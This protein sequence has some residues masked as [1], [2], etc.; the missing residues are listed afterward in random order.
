MNDR[1]RNAS[2]I[3]TESFDL[4]EET[5][6]AMKSW[7]LI[8][9][10]DVEDCFH[11]YY[12]QYIQ[13][14]QSDFAHK[15]MFLLPAL[16]DDGCYTKNGV[17][18]FF[19]ISSEYKREMMNCGYASVQEYN[20]RFTAICGRETTSL[21]LIDPSKHQSGFAFSIVSTYNKN[22]GSEV[23]RNEKVIIYHKAKNDILIDSDIEGVV[24][25]RGFPWYHDN[26]EWKDENMRYL[27]LMH[28]TSSSMLGSRK[29]VDMVGYF[30]YTGPR[31]TSQSSRSPIEPV[32]TKGHDIYNKKYCPLTYPLGVKLGRML[33]MQSD[34]VLAG[35]GNV[36]MKAAIIAKNHLVTVKRENDS[37]SK[38]GN[39]LKYQSICHNRIITKWFGSV[40]YKFLFH[41]FLVA[42]I[43]F[44][45]RHY[46]GI[47]MIKS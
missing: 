13:N 23:F 4:I 7:K 24:I 30:S 40:S 26:H 31:A 42:Y 8:D 32:V 11:I 28:G 12:V 38:S 36:L 45:F 6:K 47:L 16:H 5:A 20:S 1:K 15:K 33:C 18:N 25:F 29:K 2:S 41:T 21:K 46:T 3:R 9:R 14:Q 34:D 44:Y 17:V 22:L 19:N 35:T 43:Q 10:D 27:D 39:N 37:S